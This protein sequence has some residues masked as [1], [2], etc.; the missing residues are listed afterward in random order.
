MLEP[1]LAGIQ[2]REWQ[3]EAVRAWK[4]AGSRGIVK[5][6]TG[7]GKTVFAEMCLFDF[8]S[9]NSLRK[10][11]I[12]VPTQ[13]L[14]DQWV[15]ALQ[16]D[17]GLSAHEIATFSSEG[18]SSDLRLINIYV[19]NTARSLAALVAESGPALIIVDEVHRSGSVE[20]AKA[21]AGPWTAT[22]GLS[23]TPEREY[24]E[25]FEQH[26]VPTIGDVIFEYGY[27]RAA[28]D[29]V[30]SDFAL[31]NV[32]TEFLSSEARDYDQVNQRLAIAFGRLQNGDASQAT[33]ERLLR[34][35][36]GIA[37]RARMRIPTAVRLAELHKEART[38][39]FHESIES[40]EEICSILNS[41]G[42][43]S[44][45]YHSRLGAA[46]RRDNLRLFR[47]G[48]IR[49]L[50][51]CRALDEG[52]NVPEASVAIIASATSSSR[53][54]IQRLGRV[55]RTKANGDAAIVFTIYVTDTEERRLKKESEGRSGAKFVKW[56]KSDRR[57]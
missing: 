10:A 20:N 31:V 9:E 22:L 4:N 54:R 37:N 34:V 27:E 53:Q 49:V 42:I 13:A 36:A 33:I 18:R 19:I 7:A 28:K 15:I 47:R 16:D 21:L 25:G 50:V 8:L 46:L 5:V 57:I 38:I 32:R 6:V 51:T 1:G 24:D 48:N 11:A 14:L 2:P 26:I 56:M 30:I 45:V 55:L 12:I 29:G 41:K 23:A 40:A 43:S 35:R 52:A 39:V 17:L 44:A 3:R